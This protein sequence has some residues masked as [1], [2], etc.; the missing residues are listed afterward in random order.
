MGAL[1]LGQLC[2]DRQGGARQAFVGAPE[3]EKDVCK[4]VVQARQPGAVG[5][6]M[7][8]QMGWAGGRRVSGG[9]QHVCPIY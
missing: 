2:G 7:W 3:E 6:A 4:L 9:D 5:G 8:T 1:S